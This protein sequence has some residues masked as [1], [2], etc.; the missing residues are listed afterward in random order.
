MTGTTGIP[1]AKPDRTPFFLSDAR[2]SVFGRS[3][4]TSVYTASTTTDTSG[5]A[6]IC[7]WER[8]QKIFV[9]NIHIIISFLCARFRP[10]TTCF[11]CSSCCARIA[12][13]RVGCFIFFVFPNRRVYFLVSAVIDENDHF[14]TTF[15]CPSACT[16]VR[17]LRVKR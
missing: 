7:S 16:C 2:L 8:T 4:F 5:H 10:A 14:L 13:Y 17:V 15:P 6:M 1:S 3:V 9:S 12:C 11:Q